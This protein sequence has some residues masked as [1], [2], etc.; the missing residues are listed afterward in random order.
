MSKFM[1]ALK[2]ELAV[3]TF[4]RE[5]RAQSARQELSSI[6]LQARL[7]LNGGTDKVI[8]G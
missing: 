4:V 8:R 5:R 3:L 2:A 7:R 6:F 1:R